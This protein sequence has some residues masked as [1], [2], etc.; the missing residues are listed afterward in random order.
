MMV[1]AMSITRRSDGAA[2]SAVSWALLAERVVLLLL[3]A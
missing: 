3:A 1:A 2:A